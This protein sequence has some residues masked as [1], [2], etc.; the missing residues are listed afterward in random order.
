MSLPAVKDI[1]RTRGEVAPDIV[2]DAGTDLTGHTA[3][4]IVETAAGV[5][6][7]AIAGTVAPGA[8]TSTI[9]IT[10]TAVTV[11]DVAAAGALVYSVILNRDVTAARRTIAAGDWIVVDLAG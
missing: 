2:V 5:V 11:A 6:V 10:P 1:T 4:L 8:A 3:H 9:T 7:D